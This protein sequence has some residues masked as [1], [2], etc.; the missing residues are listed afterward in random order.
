MGSRIGVSAKHAIKYDRIQ[1]EE[2]LRAASK[3]LLGQNQ[4]KSNIGA[5]IKL[6]PNACTIQQIFTKSETLLQT[7]RY[8]P[9]DDPAFGA[10]TI[11]LCILHEILLNKPSYCNHKAHFTMSQFGSGNHMFQ[12]LC[13]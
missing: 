7:I 12:L 6:G 11:A 13:N 10:Q 5:P 9:S 4:K 1:Q 2:S 3:D 8:I